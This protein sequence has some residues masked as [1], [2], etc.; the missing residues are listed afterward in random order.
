MILIDQLIHRY[1]WELV[2]AGRPGGCNL[3]GG[4]LKQV[5]VMLNKLAYSDQSTPGLRE[6]QNR[7]QKQGRKFLKRL[8][9]SG[10][11]EADEG[12]VAESPS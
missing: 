5:T 10:A 9:R 7:W 8:E 2:N 11:F 12:T 3:I 4:T 6:V 1:H